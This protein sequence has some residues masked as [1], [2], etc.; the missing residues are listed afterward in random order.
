KG[1]HFT[2]RW[3]QARLT[4]LFCNFPRFVDLGDDVVFEI[5]KMSKGKEV[6]GWGKCHTYEEFVRLAEAKLSVEEAIQVKPVQREQPRPPLPPQSEPRPAP[7]SPV[8]VPAPPRSPMPTV[9]RP[10]AP[11]TSK[12]AAPSIEPSPPSR[13][14]DWLIVAVWVIW[15][16]VPVLLLVLLFQRGVLHLP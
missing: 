2:F 1:S 9:T 15:L 3:K 13:Q 12:P 4:A 5:R 16:L 10:S 11:P 8:S 14:V 6:H 7:S